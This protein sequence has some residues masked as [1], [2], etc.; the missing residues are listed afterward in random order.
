MG[1]LSP[2]R[3]FNL[4][5]PS[6]ARKQISQ[7]KMNLQSQKADKTPSN[8]PS[9]MT[10]QKTQLREGVII[11]SRKDIMLN[12][13]HRRINNYTK[14]VAKVRSLLDYYQ[15]VSVVPNPKEAFGEI[16]ER[17]SYARLPKILS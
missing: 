10:S 7:T 5:R 1:G 3:S 12:L 6:K 8:S 9:S 13:V 15:K 17:R 4:E 2:I 14:E 16:D 11:A